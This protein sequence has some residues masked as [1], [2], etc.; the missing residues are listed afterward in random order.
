MRVCKKCYEYKSD[1]KFR[2]TWSDSPSIYSDHCRSCEKKGK[3]KKNK[4]GNS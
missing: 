4:R 3:G 1:S 2:K